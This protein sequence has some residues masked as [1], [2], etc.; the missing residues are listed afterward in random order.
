MAGKK[1]TILIFC[2]HPDDAIL[3][4]GGTI[5][6]Y[7]KQ[8]KQIIHTVFSCD[9]KHQWLLKKIYKP[10]DI[11]QECVRASKALG[12]SK[13]IFFDIND[14]ALS[15]EIKKPWVHEKMLSLIKRYKPK[16]IYTHVTGEMRFKNHRNVHDAVLQAVHTVQYTGD[17]L[18]FPLWSLD[19]RQKPMPKLVVDIS[20]TIGQKF[21]V[22]QHFQSQ[23]SSLLQLAPVV[24][25]RNWKSALGT[26]FKYAEVFYKEQ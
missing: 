12:I 3:G 19:F 14:I 8:G 16:Q 15:K 4:M 5:A 24:F 23:K 20:Q 25:C 7:A 6:K 1:E 17:I 9:S 22:L 26:G 21:S 11:T 18:L 2:S 10:E 13:T